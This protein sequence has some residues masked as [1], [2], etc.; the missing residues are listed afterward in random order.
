MSGVLPDV[1][2]LERGEQGGQH[3]VLA[4]A[5]GPPGSAVRA[6][7]ELDHH[8]GSLGPG[9]AGCCPRLLPLGSSPPAQERSRATVHPRFQAW[10]QRMVERFGE[11]GVSED[12]GGRVSLGEGVWGRGAGLKTEV[13]EPSS[14]LGS[15]WLMTR[16]TGS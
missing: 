6:G 4:G 5:R 1:H 10:S 15:S 11:G 3:W 12:L 14:L 7:E 9:Q 16:G 2:L 13:P 8:D